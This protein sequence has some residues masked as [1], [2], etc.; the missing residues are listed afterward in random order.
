VK[1]RDKLVEAERK[2]VDDKV[3][4]IIELKNK[5]CDTPDKNFV[6]IN[7]KG[8]DPM[9]LDMLAKAGIFALRRAKRRNM[10]RLVLAC[11]GR[12]VNEVDEA[13]T[14]AVLGHADLVTET[15]LGEDKF[16]FVEGVKDPQ[17]VSILIKGP[18]SHTIAQIKDAVRDGLRAVKGA[19][20]DGV[21]STFCLQERCFSLWLTSFL[22]VLIPGAG[23]FEVACSQA[24]Q[25][26]AQT[27]PG[28]AKWGTKNYVSHLPVLLC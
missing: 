7:Q 18:N 10:E 17:S 13:L 20:E 12:Q 11:G 21:R 15:T 16:T 14:P 23:A 8:I 6:I 3:R 9:A 26:Y 28:R 2:H 19:I 22:Q 25:T 5:V 1:Q 27:V 24:M 4:K